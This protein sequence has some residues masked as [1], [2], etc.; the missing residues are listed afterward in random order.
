MYN[1]AETCKASWGGPEPEPKRGSGELNLPKPQKP[2]LF[3]WVSCSFYRAL[4]EE[5]IRMMVFIV[6]GSDPLLPPWHK[7]HCVKETCAALR[8]AGAL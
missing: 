3:F 4:Q 7:M 2:P 8:V 5:P 6:D 1:T